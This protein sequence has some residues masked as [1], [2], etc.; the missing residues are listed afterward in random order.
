MALAAAAAHVHHCSMNDTTNTGWD[1]VGAKLNGLGLKL[2]LHA[3]QAAGDERESVGQ[4]LKALAASI[5]KAFDALRGA[6]KDPAIQE[7]VKSVGT[8]LSNAVTE[9]LSGV[10]DELRKTLKR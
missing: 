3:E 9:T 7:D 8:A 4:A 5:D 10:G 1:D 6:A 2:K